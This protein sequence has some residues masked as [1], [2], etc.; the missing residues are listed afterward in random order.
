M[1]RI[2]HVFVGQ[3]VCVLHGNLMSQSHKWSWTAVLRFTLAEGGGDPI[4]MC[5]EG[6]LVRAVW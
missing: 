5:T 4:N 2:M 1:L 3:W 6:Q